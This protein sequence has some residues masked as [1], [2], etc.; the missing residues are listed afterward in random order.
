MRQAA[1]GYHEYWPDGR[2]IFQ[3]KDKQFNMW[4]NEG[5]HLRVMVMIEGPDIRKVFGKLARG[6]AC[7]EREVARVTATDKP[8]ARHPILGMV[9]CCPTNLG[10][11]C[12]ASV[13]MDLPHLVKKLTIHGIDEICDQNKCQARGSTG[14]FSEVT[15]GARVDISNKYRLGYSEVQLVEHMI[16]TAN[17]LAT[18]ENIA[19]SEA[20]FLEGLPETVDESFCRAN[21]SELWD[22]GLSEAF[23]NLP[24]NPDGTI[25]KEHYVA[26]SKVDPWRV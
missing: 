14:E 6:V 2:G 26:L 1:C 12:R 17:I 15:Q 7:V 9:T 19:A 10:T 4:I 16:R 18:L 13:H 21:A 23:K 22:K 24:H 3:A 11:G 25:N 5:D 8:F 20:R